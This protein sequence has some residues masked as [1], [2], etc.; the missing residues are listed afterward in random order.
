MSRK[1]TLFAALIIGSQLVQVVTLGPTPAGGMVSDL[2]GIAAAAAAA[3]ACFGAA[4]RARGASHPFWLLFGAA[5]VSQFAAD[6]VWAYFQDWRGIAAA[7][8]AVA[9]DTILLRTLFLTMLVFRDPDSKRLDLGSVIDF[10]QLAII[11]AL[12]YLMV[13]YTAHSS[14]G[15][16]GVVVLGLWLG[17]LPRIV[18][19]AVTLFQLA[20]SRGKPV[21]RLQWTFLLYLAWY[22]FGEGPVDYVLGTRNLPTGSWMDLAWTVPPLAVAWWAAG[23]KEETRPQPVAH[24]KPL[25]ILLVAN[26]PF[27]LAPMVVLL[28]IAELGSEYQVLR[29]SLLALSILCFAARLGLSEY[30][31]A[32]QMDSLRLQERTLQAQSAFLG[33]LIE[34]APE[35]IVILNQEWTVERINGEFTRLFGYAPDEACGRLLVDLIVPEEYFAEMNEAERKVNQGLKVAL[36]T[37]RRHKDGTLIEVSALASLVDLPAGRS[38]KIIVFRDNRE[39]KRVE[40]QLLQSQRMEA[41]GRLAGGVAHDFNNLLTVINGYSGLLLGKLKSGDPSWDSIEEILKAGKRAAALTQQLLAFSRK[42]VLQP[43]V[44]DFNRV[45]GGMQPMLARLVGED[46]DLHVKLH[47]EALPICADPHQLE[48]VVMNLAANSRDAMPQGGKLMIE[49]GVVEWGESHV[50]FAPEAR[51]G[52]YVILTVSDTGVGIDEETR[53][54]IFEPFFTTKEVG[55]GTGLGLSM[56]QGIVE[57]SGGYLE[58]CGEPGAGTTFRIFL[59]SVTE[60]VPDEGE[61]ESVPALG[62]KETV[63]VVEDQAEVRK[64]TSAALGSYGYRVIQAENADEALLL[65]ER[66]REHVDLV[67]TDVVMPNLSGRE[68]ADRIGKRRPGIKVLF[69]SGYTND[70]IQHHGVLQQGADFIQKPF[71]PDQL[72]IKVR[73]MLAAPDRPARIVVADD[74]PGVRSFLRMVLEASGYEVIEAVDGRQALKEALAKRVDL[75]IT[76]LV[77]PEREGIETKQALRRDMSD[78]RIMAISAAFDGKFLKT[79]QAVGA[80]VVLNKPM[81]AELLLARVA[82]VLKLRR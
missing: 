79:A 6:V 58:V 18:L 24:S 80:D 4:K 2:L 57:Q 27:A 30:R 20:R 82:E 36:D 33:Q 68:L 10:V 26:A 9:R 70:S 74:D 54:H 12:S 42:Q 41:V 73:E 17:M 64:Y 63:L 31:Q 13:D 67:L 62:G 56:I 48:Q 65:C 29:Y 69:M 40:M 21:D 16:T 39:R 46:V 81:S 76:D 72:A 14:V 52:S 32:R 77:M 28:Q 7:S 51:M 15:P 8:Q 71:S 60:A 78:V 61:P 66:E 47:P 43:H 75:V 59:P 11:Y 53:R 55:K 34:G 37:V 22:L 50:Q 3:A 5:M 38:G 35:A 45:V 44:L 23:W 25:A 1:L 19:L 49:T